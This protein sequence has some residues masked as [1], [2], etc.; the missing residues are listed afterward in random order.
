MLFLLA[1]AWAGTVAWLLFRAVRQFRFYQ[2][3]RPGAGDAATERVAA[4]ES[5]AEDAAQAGGAAEDAAGT[6]AAPAVA[7]IVPVRDEAR[8]IARCLEGLLRQDYPPGRLQIIVV[9]DGS[10]DGTAAIVRRFADADGRV[11]LRQGRLLPPGWT[12][13]AFACWQGAVSVPPDC[14]W[15]CFVDADTAAAP[16]LLRRAV[17]EA[18]RRRIDML[19]LEPSQDLGTVWE[20]L[21]IPA[22]YFLLA[23][24][25]DVRPI[26]DPARPE[27]TANGQFILIRRQVYRAIGG[28]ARVRAEICEDN[29]LAR[30][31]K[32]SGRRLALLGAESLIRT[33]MYTGWRDLWE[34]FSKNAVEMAGGVA[35]ALRI[36]GAGLVLGWAALLLPV[37]AGSAVAAAPAEPLGIAALALALA[38]SL[39]AL[40]VHIAG[41]RHFRIPL[42]YGLL[43]PLGYTLAA[44]I[45]VN[46][47]RVRWRRRIT[48]K[49]RSY[50]LPAAPA[51]QPLGGDKA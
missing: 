51:E 16:A 28:H 46:S 23:C 39:A 41:A 2:T 1:F 13:K 38:G 47:V 25:L 7:V 40:G 50:P 17:A 12:G 8:C 27:A 35:D 33:R 37:A 19:S 43:F 22:G 15:L 49:G 34:G 11:E 20:R 3:I 6:E 18:R 5:A 14:D 21:V 45:A 24:S 32:G 42:W 44:A 9:D 48:W 4:Q 29:A 10:T 30:A 26:N 36:A 31:V